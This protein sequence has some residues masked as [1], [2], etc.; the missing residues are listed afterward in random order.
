MYNLIQIHQHEHFGNDWGFYVDIETSYASN[1][2]NFDFPQKNYNKNKFDKIHEDLE[3][4]EYNTKKES[5]K[6]E[7]FLKKK[8]SSLLFN[9][10]S[11]ALIT[12]AISYCFS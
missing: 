3:Y 1:K 4:Y 12:A 2:V 7:E 8:S 11:I 10:S 9:I 5:K 6:I